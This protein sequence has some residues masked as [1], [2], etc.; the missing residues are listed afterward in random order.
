[1]KL[2]ILNFKM[3][4][5]LGYLAVLSSLLAACGQNYDLPTPDPAE[6]PTPVLTGLSGIFLD[7][8]LSA[9]QKNFI[10]SDI[11]YIHDLPLKAAANTY[12]AKAFKGTSASAVLNYLSERIH[13]LVAPSFEVQDRVRVLA[14][15]NGDSGPT[16]TVQ[17]VATNL[18]TSIWL[19]TLSEKRKIVLVS[20]AELIPILSS[21]VGIIRL[22]ESY[23]SFGSSGQPLPVIARTSVLVH[24]ARHSDCTKVLSGADLQLLGNTG[25]ADRTN[26]IQNHEC[27]HLHTTCPA[28][29]EYEGKPACDSSPWGAYSIG[30]LYADGIIQTCKA[31][32]C[33]ENSYQTALAVRIDSLSRLDASTRDKLS[34]GTLPDPDM[35]SVDIATN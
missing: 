18:G 3:L 1:M 31:A 30:A 19:G 34:N 20:G 35:G 33:D 28:G 32:S 23:F 17:T 24:E 15:M 13:Y 4:T 16:A 10:R 7:S 6:N 26:K 25:D 12:F 14:S 9:G 27:G 8:T 29:T 2:S 21:R 5:H 11:Q 22:G